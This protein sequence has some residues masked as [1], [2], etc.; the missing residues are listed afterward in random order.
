MSNALWMLL[1]LSALVAAC[2]LAAFLLLGVVALIWTIV[3]AIHHRH[4]LRREYR[5]GLRV[6]PMNGP[7]KRV[8]KH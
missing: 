6:G 8:T 3:G 2:V 1:V 5:L 7:A 4:R